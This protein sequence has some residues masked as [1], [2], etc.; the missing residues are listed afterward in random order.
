MTKAQTY[1]RI[2]VTLPAEVLAQADR[3]ARELGRSRSWI[4]AEA[5]RREASF[6]S[7]THPQVVAPGRVHEPAAPPYVAASPGLGEQR[8]NQLKADMALTTER[9]VRAA[10]E[11]VRIDQ[12]RRGSKR[13]VIIGFEKYADYLSWKDKQRVSR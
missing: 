1:A 3:L 8:L 5:V 6:R 11:T 7:R 4:I 9:R 12:V 2:S 10:E 13:E